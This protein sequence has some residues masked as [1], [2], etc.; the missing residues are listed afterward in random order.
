MADWQISALIVG[1][2]AVVGGSL[3]NI[4]L[5]MDRIERHFADI[6]EALQNRPPKSN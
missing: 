2:F 3:W 5:K 6:V 1:G 4:S